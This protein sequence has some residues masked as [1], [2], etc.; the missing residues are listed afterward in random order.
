MLA[1][2]TYRPHLPATFA[3]EL[4]LTGKLR[5]VWPNALVFRVTEDNG[6]KFILRRPDNPD[7]TLGT[8][9]A[10]ARLALYAL[11]RLHKAGAPIPGE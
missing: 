5:S 6:E 1:T 8:E 10:E 7:I 11:I 3:V 9:F 2:L 4:Y